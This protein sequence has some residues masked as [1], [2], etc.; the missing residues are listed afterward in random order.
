MSEEEFFD[1]LQRNPR[2]VVVDFWAPWCGPCR[3]IEPS[4]KRLG[5]EY[6]ERIDLWRV[7]AD[8]HPGLLRGLKIYGIPTLVA[9]HQ[10]QEVARRSGVASP[11]VLS[12]LFEAALSGV[13]PA[14]QGPAPLDRILRLVTG[15]A[16]AILA[17]QNHFAGLS[18]FLAGLGA[19]VIFSA[20]YDHCPIY[21]TLAAR[22]NS[23]LHP[24]RPDRANF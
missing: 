22:V 14:R 18:L 8:E 24:G 6:N 16:L 13:K 11:E 5:A 4:L 7:N 15:G 10:G 19:V 2:P 1:R 9:F 3:A 17:Y 12:T 20:V 21:R 23:W